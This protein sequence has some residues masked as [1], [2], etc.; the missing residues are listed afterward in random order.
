MPCGE[1]RHDWRQATGPIGAPWG[2][3]APGAWSRHR[4]PSSAEADLAG[5]RSLG[6]E[7]LARADRLGAR[8]GVRLGAQLGK[9]RVAH[10]GQSWAAPGP[11]KPPAMQ[12][13]PF[14]PEP[15]SRPRGWTGKRAVAGSP[16]W[17]AWERLGPDYHQ[18]AGPQSKPNP[19]SNHLANRHRRHGGKEGDPQGGDRVLALGHGEGGDHS[20]PQTSN[21]QLGHDRGAA[22]HSGIHE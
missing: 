2:P 6:L 21:G 5:S 12:D 3:R 20:S 13:Q 10:A 7:R 1:D 19:C 17:R 11:N 16:H 22:V 15:R 8:L 14:G 18:G 4:W 9:N